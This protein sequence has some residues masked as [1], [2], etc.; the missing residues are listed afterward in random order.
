[1]TNNNKNLRLLY[2]MRV[3]KNFSSKFAFFFLP[4]FLYKIGSNLNFGEF[5]EIQRGML[6]IAGF[7][8]L[9]RLTS[10]LSVMPVGNLIRK[11][12]PKN[13]LMI[14]HF[15]RLMSLTLLILGE[16]NYFLIFLASVYE[17]I[18]VNFFWLSSNYLLGENM[19]N[20]QLGKKLGVLNSLLQIVSV[21]S[22]LIS[23]L[24]AFYFGFQSLFWLGMFFVF[25]CCIFTYFIRDSSVD[26]EI[27][28][29]EF[30]SW[31]R[32]KRYKRLMISF[33][34]GYIYSESLYLWT[35]YI[36]LYLGDIKKVGYLY[37]IS[38]VLVFIVLFFTAKYLD[39]GKKSKKP[40]YISGGLISFLWLIRTQF[41]GLFFLTIIDVCEKLAFN[42]YG[43]FFDNLLMKR[44]VGSQS[45]SYFVYRNVIIS[46]SGLIFWAFFSLVFS[47]GSS[48]WDN[49]FILTSFGLIL[50]LLIREKEVIK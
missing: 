48:G 13:G 7:F 16:N 28:W 6:F 21:I 23:G 31:F 20:R 46:V 42:V 2:A 9:A 18:Y 10:L 14:A 44:S 36:F 15:L 49:V 43:L 3:A 26:D 45:Y 19:K 12:K 24:I 30:F 17:G 47:L 41:I 4:I 5:D 40:F 35:L 34:G 22:P 11:I 27:S 1:M 33:F 25:L 37:T 32:E 29:Q 8:L 50:S 39:S 38:V